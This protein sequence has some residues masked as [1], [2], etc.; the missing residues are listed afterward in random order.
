MYVTDMDLGGILI[1]NEY[2]TYS[3]FGEAYGLDINEGVEASQNLVEA[4]ENVLTENNVEFRTG[5]VYS[6]LWFYA[7][8]LIGGGVKP[9]SIIE[10]KINN[11]EMVAKEMEGYVLQAIANYY[12]KEAV[13]VLTG[14]T[15]IKGENS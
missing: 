3:K 8:E 15:K 12:N 4:F 11:G 9:G 5:G 10:Q 1:G 14:S 7:P 2:F 13:T 6:S